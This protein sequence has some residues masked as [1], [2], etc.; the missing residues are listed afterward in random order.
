M[1]TIFGSPTQKKIL[2]RG[3]EIFGRPCKNVPSGGEPF[4][5]SSWPFLEG[6]VGWPPRLKVSFVATVV[7]ALASSSELSFC[8]LRHRACFASTVLSPTSSTSCDMA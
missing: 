4:P 1:K 2:D 6:R 5:P 8:A 3:K 7:S